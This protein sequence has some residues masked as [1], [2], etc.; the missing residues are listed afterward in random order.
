MTTIEIKDPKV[1]YPSFGDPK[2]TVDYTSG[3]PACTHAFV[4]I[5]PRDRIVLCRVCRAQVDPFDV[6][7]ELAREW[8]WATHF[9]QEA[10]ERAD[11]VERLKAEEANVKARIRKVYRGAPEPKSLLYYEEVL[12][13]LNAA[14]TFA[15]L[16]E[17]RAWAAHFP[18]LDSKQTEVT[19]DAMTRAEE[20]VRRHARK[21]R[22][23][24]LAVVGA[25]GQ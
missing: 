12:R 22:R 13:R 19:K 5:R 15:E 1:V 10:S 4:V 7:R 14:E 23:K 20:R 2:I 21:H 18:W 6:L 8:D 11:R 3:P 25:K 9:S 24:R 16:Q 17:V